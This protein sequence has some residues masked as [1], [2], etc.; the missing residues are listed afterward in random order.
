MNEIRHRDPLKN[1]FLTFPT[2]KLNESQLWKTLWQPLILTYGAIVQED[3]KD[4]QKH[5][6]AIIFLKNKINKNNLLK[7]LKRL[8][9]DD[10]KRI[11]IRSLR[12]YKFAYNY[13]TKFNDPINFGELPKNAVKNY[14][15]MIYGSNYMFAMEHL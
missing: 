12:S 6:H 1:Y 13:M 3:H 5:L 14:M 8:F 11:H 9:P 7:I 2:C 10:W 15:D 4:G